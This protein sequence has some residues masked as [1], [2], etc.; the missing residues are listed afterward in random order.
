MS[1]KKLTIFFCIFVISF[2]MVTTSLASSEIYVWSPTSE[3]LNN[4]IQTSANVTNSNTNVVE[5]PT[6]NAT[7]SEVNTAENA[8]SNEVTNTLSNTS[9][10]TNT[11]SVGTDLNLEC[12]GAVLIEQN[13]GRVLYDHNMHQKLRPASVTK[14]MSLLLIM[15][16]ID[17]GRLSYTDKI[18]C[19]EEAAAMGGSQIW[20]DVREELTVDEMLKAICVV[21]ANDCT[22]AMAEYLAG[23]QEAFVAQ[24]N[25][26]AKELG[27]NDTT[28][29]NCHGIDEDGHETSA[30][31]IALMS[32]ELLTKHH[33]ITKYTTIWMDS[34]R[35]GKSELVNTNKLI[36]NYKGATGLKTGS[37]SIAL[38]NL[39]ASATRDD[40]S[41][42]AVVM[43]APTTKIRFAEAEKLLDY[44]FNNFQ[45]SKFANANDILKTISVE[46]GVKDNI[47]L[48]YENSAGALIKKGESKNVEQTINIP[49]KISAPINKGDVVG[50]IVYTVDGNEISRVN[51]IANETVEKNNLINMINYIFTKWSF[52]N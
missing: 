50:N 51:I 44:G 25:D 48:T 13:S 39:S 9:T 32:R 52:R 19:T 45:Y 4:S 46:K 20:L 24:M 11:T 1:F 43:K 27:M 41:L 22:V 38:Y 8:T 28:F 49:D 30:Y 29:K 3:P 14:V 26:K 2:F 12:G 7:S 40:L 23:S 47:E 37:T 42:I 34:L 10:L 18:P 5:T 35:D 21:S 31:D 16:A 6:K 17:S 36:R 15:E 33:D